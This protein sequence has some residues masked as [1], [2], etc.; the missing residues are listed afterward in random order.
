MKTWFFVCVAAL[1]VNGAGQTQTGP[2]AASSAATNVEVGRAVLSAPRTFQ[3]SRLARGAVRTPRPTGGSAG[4]GARETMTGEGAGPTNAATV[5][6]NTLLIEA[7]DFEAEG[8]WRKIPATEAHYFATL[9]NTFHSRGKLL[10][11]PEQG[12]RSVAALKVHIPADG[13]YRIW[14][15]YECPSWWSVEHTVRINQ[16][17]GRVFERT[18]GALANPKLWPFGKGLQPMVEWDWGSG[19]NVVWEPSDSGVALTKGEAIIRLIADEQPEEQPRQRGAARRNIDCIFLTTDLEDGIR[20][21]KKAFYHTF[22]RHL[23]Q[24]GDCWMRVVNRAPGILP[25]RTSSDSAAPRFSEGATRQD[26]GGTLITVSLRV[27]EHNPYWQKRGP[28]PERIGARGAFKGEPTAED[29]LAPGDSTPWIA[30][31]QALDTLNVQELYVTLASKPP[32]KSMDV[33]IE[34]ARKPDVGALLRSIRCTNAFANTVVF[35][36]PPDLRHASMARWWKPPIQTI[37]EWHRELLDDLRDVPAGAWPK[38]VPVFGILGGAWGGRTNRLDEFYRLRTETGLLLGRNT[39]RAGEVPDDLAKRFAVEPRR[40]LEIDVR[41]TPTEKLAAALRQHELTNQIQFVSLGDEI[42][43]GG[44]DAENRK[45]Q[46]QFRAYLTRLHSLP[47]DQRAQFYAIHSP[48]PDPGTAKLTKNASDGTNFYWSQLF[49]IDRGIDELKARTE[50]VERMLGTNVFTGANYGPHPHYWPRVGQ[51]VRMFRRHGMT[52]PWAEDW[53]FQ[54]AE[55]SMQ[56]SGYLC[57]VFRCA[58]KYENLPIQFY[59]MPHWPGQTPRDLTLSFYSALAHGNKVLNFFAAK[60]IYDYTENYI[61]WEARDNWR[62]VQRL[63]RDVGVAD[64][65]IWNGRVR[66]ARVAILLSHATDIYEEARGSSIYN[67]ERKNLYLALRHAGV[68]VDFATEEDVCEGW[69]ERSGYRVLYVCGDHI[70]RECAARVRDWVAGG[71]HLFGVAGGGFL[72][73]Y[74]QP[75]DTLKPVYGVT[76]QKLELT[77]KHCFAKEGLAW[78][79]PLDHWQREPRLPCLIA[80]QTFTSDDP[81]AVRLV[82][83]GTGAVLDRAHGRGRAT[84]VGTFPGSAY[85]QPAIPKRPFDRG[86]TDRSFNHFLPT[87][88]DRNAQELILAPVRAANVIEDLQLSASLIDATVVESPHGWAIPLAN[89]SG[90]RIRRLAVTFAPGASVRAVHSARRGKLNA[91]TTSVGL[92]VTLPLD[93]ADLLVLRR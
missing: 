84:I 60:P 92:R 61:A 91:A 54:V 7:E 53:T 26:A 13:I 9:A 44:Y 93:D 62:T 56:M 40:N 57:D 47:A 25:G 24:T 19:D 36:I 29:W 90:Q 17:G 77:E 10:S 42:H 65:I 21:A 5:V 64:D 37:E 80:K 45:Q 2:A 15:R 34:F 39:W 67:F 82:S 22:D 87:A 18:Y 41:G 58:A 86:T 66:P 70:L 14:T 11:A 8:E 32:R 28:T 4:G 23:A 43:V 33:L 50:I 71:G 76:E 68:A 6:T 38:Q 20:D 31:G 49:Q 72:D 89:Y 88:F 74:N 79:K 59:T 46:E 35:Q 78:L 16:G 3:S 1:A 69:L 48:V 51:W 73:E 52:M 75:L 81:G 55:V 83:G 85:V 12:R 30:I 63:V 27:A